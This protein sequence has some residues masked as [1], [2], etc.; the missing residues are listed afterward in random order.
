M[1][2]GNDLKKEDVVKSCE[3]AYSKPNTLNRYAEVCVCFLHLRVCI[4]SVSM[5]V[6]V[7]VCVCLCLCLSMSVSVSMKCAM[8]AM[9]SND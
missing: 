1:C 9:A 6:S 2:L 3:A 5:S 4:L 7:Y 8:R